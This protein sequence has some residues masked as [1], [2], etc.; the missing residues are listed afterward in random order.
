MPVTEAW[1][2]IHLQVGDVPFAQKSET[3]AA[4]WEKAILG[5][6][7][8]GRTDLVLKLLFTPHP[9]GSSFLLCVP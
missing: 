5:T 3:Q 2:P 9:Q 8:H 4:G 6:S 1:K 7:E